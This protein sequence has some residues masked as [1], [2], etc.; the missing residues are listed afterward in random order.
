MPRHLLKAFL[1]ALIICRHVNCHAQGHDWRNLQVGDTASYRVWAKVQHNKTNLYLKR[2]N[3]YR[4]QATGEWQDADFRPTDAN[5]FVGFTKAMKIGQGLK[6]MP[7]QNYLKLLAR[8][9]T[10]KIP[11]GTGCTFKPT[12]SGRL[13]LIPNDA[14]FFFGNNSGSLVVTI[15]RTG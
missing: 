13:I 9:G 1:A 5:G 2:G 6:P 15:T 11:V 7:R 14:R 8:V 3:T 4:I 12:Q 10:S